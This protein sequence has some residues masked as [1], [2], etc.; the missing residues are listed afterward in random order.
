MN[1]SITLEEFK[2]TDNYN[3]FIEANPSTGTLKVQ[4]FTADQAIPIP[5]TEVHIIKEIDSQ[6]IIF[7]KGITDSSGIIDNIKL[8]TPKGDY[9]ISDF[10]VPEYTT[11]KLMVN[12]DKYSTIKE[13][14][15]AMF[16]GV[17]ILQYIKMQ[18]K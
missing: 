15:V 16:G 11:Y 7:Y 1:N 14:D 5:N 3:K 10:K 12:N 4:V 2:K 18:P 17:K 13:Y 6:N 8:P 9:N